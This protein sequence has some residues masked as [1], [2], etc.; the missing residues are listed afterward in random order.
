MVS[1]TIVVML[2]YVVLNTL[3]YFRAIYVEK[4]IQNFSTSLR[5]T[6]IADF[7]KKLVYNE[8]HNNGA[9]CIALNTTDIQQFEQYAANCLFAIYSISLVVISTIALLKVNIT[10]FIISLA[11]SLLM[12]VLPKYF[13][14]AIKTTTKDI[15]KATEN[16]NK[17]LENALASSEMLNNFSALNLLDRIVNVGSKNIKNAKVNRKKSI[18]TLQGLNVTINAGNQIALIFIAGY[19]AYKGYIEFAMIFAISGYT[20]EFFGGLTKVIELYPNFASANELL[21]K[22]PEIKEEKR[23]PRV[24]K[25]DKAIVVSNV[26]YNYPDKTVEFPNLTFEKNKK[27]LIK[28]KSGSGKSTLINILNGDLKNYEGSVE[29]DNRELKQFDIKSAISTMNQKVQLLNLSIK[30]NIILNKEYNDKLF[31]EVLENCKLVDVIDNLEEKENT[32]LDNK[33]LALSGGQLQRLGLARSLYHKKDVFIIDEGTANLDS[34]L[35]DDIE[36][37]ILKDKEST[38]IMITHRNSEKI[39][40]LADKVIT[41]GS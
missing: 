11:L 30:D 10:L 12:M 8:K 24:E 14:K 19:F 29:W 33:N 41:L 39:E 5:K 4:L 27:Y 37:I 40:N 20:G 7:K 9:E 26:K 17:D 15:S 6:A 32:I 38:V 25:L 1:A 31:R 35:A 3:G 16:F 22:Y 23:L 13:N 36:E 2:I 18:M 28:G 21:S 34:K